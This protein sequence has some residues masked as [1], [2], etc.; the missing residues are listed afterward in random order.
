MGLEEEHETEAMDMSPDGQLDQRPRRQ[1]GVREPWRC[2]NHFK[3]G[4]GWGSR[5]STR[6]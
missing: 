5:D 1:V 2:C 3:K 6:G 4:K